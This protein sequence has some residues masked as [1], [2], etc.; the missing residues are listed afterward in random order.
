MLKRNSRPL[1]ALLSLIIASPALA[2]SGVLTGTVVNSDTKAPV[3]DVVVTVTS[4]SL[5]GE[6]VVV[7]D[8]AGVYGVPNLPPGTYALRIE[9][10]EYRAQKT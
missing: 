6:Q 7:T 2:Q 4:P 1:F 3:A 8:A 5:Q 10:E 9:R